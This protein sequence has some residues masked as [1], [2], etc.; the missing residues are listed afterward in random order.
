MHPEALGDTGSIEIGSD[1]EESKDD[2]RDSEE[3][4]LQKHSFGLTCPEY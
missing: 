1:G 4:K 2:A 3:M